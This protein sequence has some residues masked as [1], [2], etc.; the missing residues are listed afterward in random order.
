M[1]LGCRVS[2][3]AQGDSLGPHGD[4]QGTPGCGALLVVLLAAPGAG[5]TRPTENASE[6][7]GPGAQG[8]EVK[9]GEG[10]VGKTWEDNETSLFHTFP[11]YF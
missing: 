6:V 5:Q 11:A 2:M 1:G 3:E 10:D 7:P 9:V 4:A 8:Q